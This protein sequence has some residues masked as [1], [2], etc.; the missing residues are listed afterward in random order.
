M[1]YRLLSLLT[2]V[3]LIL[4]SFTATIPV[5]RTVPI[6][7]EAEQVTSEGVLFRTTVTLRQPTE[8]ASLAKLGIVVLSETPDQAVVLVD[9]DQ[10]ETLARLRFEPA[11]SD[12]FGALVAAN[13]PQQPWLTESLQPLVEKAQQSAAQLAQSDQVAR[14]D[15]LVSLRAAIQTLSPEQMAGINALSS[16]DEDG[17]QLTNTQEAWWCTDTDNPD[18]DND[19]VSDF[20]EVKAAR[21]WLANRRSS[22]PAS[23]TPYR[24][25]PMVP[26][27]A[28]FDANCIDHDQDVVPD[29]AE[30]WELGLNP[31]RESTS[32]DKF[33]DGQKLF[34]ITKIN[35]GARPGLADNN[36]IGAE[37]P[38]WVKAPGNHPMV[39]AYPVPEVSVVPGTWHVNR[40]TTITTQQGTMMQS[41]KT[42]GSAVT[43][44]TSDSIANS[45]TWNNWEEVLQAVERPLAQAQKMPTTPACGPFCNVIFVE[46]QNV[47]PVIQ[48]QAPLWQ[49][50]IT[51]LGTMII[52]GIVG[53]AAWQWVQDRFRGDEKKVQQQKYEPEKLYCT[54]NP[55]INK[56]DA[57]NTC[58]SSSPNVQASANAVQPP[59]FQGNGGSL[60]GM[61]FA[62][63]QQGALITNGLHDVAYAISQPRLTETRTSG[64]SWGGA[65][66]TTHTEM[67]EHTLSESQAFTTG[68]N[69]S[70]AWAVDTSHAADLTFN[71]TVKN[72]G[73]EYAREILGLVFNVYLGNDTV[74]IVSYPAW[75]QFPAGK[76]QN[77]FPGDSFN[78]AST[79]IPLTLEQMKRIDLG[80]RLTVALENY[81][82]GVDQL[83]YQ[84]AVNGGVTIFTEGG[85]DDAGEQIDSYV[86][87]T[88]GAESVQ[89]VLTRYFPHQLDAEGLLN[90]L[91]TP[92]FVNNV[93]TWHEHYLSD[94]AWWNIYLSQSDAGNTELRDLPAQAGSA[95]FFRF[96]RDSDRD[97][98]P[99]RS[100]VQYGTDPHDPAS[101]PQ[102]ELLACY[103][104]TRV[105]N[106]VT[107]TLALDNAGTFDA[108]HI[109]AVM[110]SPDNTTTIGNNTVGG[111]GRVRPG[112]HVA[113]GSLIKQPG[114]GNWGANTARVYSTGDYGGSVDRTYTFT[115]N[116]PGV[117]GQGSA[118]MT[119]NDGA[120]VTGTLSLGASYHAPLPLDVSQ[121]LQV[122]FNTGTLNASTSFTVTAFS[123]RDT[124]TYTINS[125]PYTPPVIVVS[126]S[127]PQ[128]AHRFVT[129]VQLPDLQ[130]SLVPTYTGQMLTE[131][132]L[133]IATT[134][135]VSTTG[136]NT[137]NFIL[138]SPAASA[139]ADAHLY[140][141]FV[142]NG[143]LVLHQP[144]T[145][146]L[147]A[148]PMVYSAVWS[149]AQF[150]Q[151][152][153][154]A[155]DNILIAHWTDSEGNI[156][157][158]AARPLNTFASDPVPA[159]AMNAADQTWNF[160]TVTQG[161]VLQHSFTIASTGFINLAAYLGNT[162][163]LTVT[164]A[165]SRNLAPGDTATYT[166][167][168]NTLTQATSAFS[169]TLKLRTSDPANPTLTFTVLGNIIAPTGAANA[170]DL[171][172]RPWDK[173]VMVY[174]NV[175]QYTP[176]DFAENIQPDTASI[177]PCMVYAADGT[178]LK[179]IGKACADFGGGVS[180]GQMFGDGSDG[181]IAINSITAF[182]TPMSAL[183]NTASAGQAII[184]TV[185]A[186]PFEPGWEILLIQMQGIGTG[187]YEFAQVASQN[188][189]QTT[190][191]KPLMHTYIQSG[192]SKVFALKVPHFNNVTITSNGEWSAP[193]WDGSVGGILIFR[194][195]GRVDIQAGG[196]ITVKGRGYRS[197]DYTYG[198]ASTQQSQGEGYLGVGG[199]SSSS[200]SGGGGGGR[201][202]SGDNAYNSKGAG[203]GG[204][205]TAGGT[206]ATGYGQGGGTFGLP[207]LS[208]SLTAGGAG[209]ISG[210]D[211]RHTPGYRTYAFARN[212][213]GILV[214]YASK[215]QSLGSVTADG[216]SG[217]SGSCSNCEGAGGAGGSLYLVVGD[218][219]ASTVTAVG[220]VHYG[221]RDDPSGDG[222]LGRIR[223]EYCNSL[224]GTTNPP[225]STQ[226]LTCY[227]AE[228]T[229]NTNVHFTVPDA[230]T[231]SQ[232]YV[233]Q[234]GRYFAFGASGGTIMTPT[235]LLA[236]NYTNATMDALITNVGA[237]GSTNLQVM[238]GNQTVYSASQTITQPTS[239]S[240]GNFASALNAYL[241]A[242]PANTLIDVPM[243]VTLNR[244]ADV[245]LTNLALTP[246]ANVDASIAPDDI[247]FGAVTPTE[248]TTVPIT[249]TLHNT[250]NADS[251]G[252]TA[253]V[254]AT[255]T[256][257]STWYIGSAYVP[258]IPANGTM[259]AAIQ[260][261]TLGFTGTTPV[262]V[263]I[264][265]YNR[266]A[267]T[268]ENNNTV[269]T[270]LTIRT[271]PDLNFAALTLFNDEP[272]TNE[273]VTVT[274]PLHNLGQTAAGAY[275]VALYQGN[276]DAD[277]V[278]IGAVDQSGLAGNAT[279]PITF[280][281]T[282][283]AT[284]SYRLFARADRSAQIDEADEGNNDLWMDV[285]V[286][287]R[288]PIVIDSGAASDEPYTSTLGHGYVDLGQ[289]DVLV[290][291]GSQPHETLRMDP[292]GQIGYRFDHL[293][294]G[295]FYHLDVTLYECD[296]AGR[297]E[298]I[299][300]DGNRIAGPEDLLDGRVHRLS[301]R[302]DPALYADRTISVT[303][304][305]PSIDGAVVS[306]I[307][308]YDIDY[309]YADAGGPS[310]PAY[311]GGRWT[312]FG[313]A[314][315]YT[316]G[317]TNT[318]WGT[319]PYSNVH[320]NQISNTV[321]YRFDGLLPAKQY[322]VNLTFW[323]PSGASRAQKI[324]IDNVDTGPTINT[325]DYQ[326]HQLTVDVPNSAYAD[327]RI[328]VGIVRTNAAT[329]AFVNEIALE[330]LTAVLPPVTNFT[331][332]PT[333]G[334]APLTVQ[335]TDQ[336]SGVITSRSWNFGDG[337]TA[338]IANPLHA[339]QLSGT[340]TVSLMTTGPGGTDIL[341]RTNFITATPITTQTVMRIN[342]PVSSASVGLPITVAVMISNVTN[343][344]S[345]QFTLGFDPAR[346]QV[347]ALTLGEFP[348]S[349][350]RTFTPIGPT[351]DNGNGTA[352]FGAFSL[353]GTPPG[354][355]GSGNLAYIRLQPISGGVTALTLSN[356]QASTVSGG[357]FEVI[358]QTGTLS[359][360]ACLGDFDGDG[361]VDILD[362]Q[363]VA[364]RWGS[365][366][367]QA[368]YD[369]LYDVEPL[370][371]P[372]GDIG[373]LD[374]QVVA[375]RWGTQCSAGQLARPSA[376]T[377]PATL[378]IQPYS[379]TVSVNQIF[380]IS[381]WI[382]DV[383]DLGAFE[384][385]LAY[386]PTLIEVMSATIAPF[387]SSTGRAFTLA[388]FII[389]PTASTATYGA[390]SLGATPAGVNGNGA[391][392]ILTLKAL[393]AGQSGVNFTAAQISDRSG[394][395]QVI[396]S[397]LNGVVEVVMP[398]EWKVY[399]PAVLK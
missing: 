195:S 122:G 232:N 217:Y 312:T 12:E 113:V 30:T 184:N 9:A 138:N 145:L 19:G 23:G 290:P 162:S 236:Q 321:Y 253:A 29:A 381:V 367:G 191:T 15:A 325:G 93:P 374:V 193:A 336:S 280:T 257:G 348:G 216:E 391:L 295:H 227:I 74:P 298:N 372:D 247:T 396:G 147:N 394:A 204:H 386:S 55:Q 340:Y 261:N 43:R 332:A 186:Q 142:S 369:P 245:M 387:P 146:T 221:A 35:W 199:Q 116:I 196:Q 309:R 194:A 73:M 202:E 90:S 152:Y 181:D 318:L 254:F 358:T 240:L 205:A 255:P 174:G 190:L 100:E 335:F 220:G 44:G 242:Q 106:I 283:T 285:Y 297:Q 319:L 39:A 62:L 121:G 228:K 351:I 185:V 354:P 98:Y 111:N 380:T 144:Y 288:G 320:V 352:T 308:L 356:V 70:T 339:Y 57:N 67:E 231:N 259:Q 225:A 187:T 1:L 393:S 127:D 327:G 260:W 252:L 109:S 139:I 326:L 315:G 64:R 333:F 82:Y 154:A 94:I 17:D 7:K 264:D 140:V 203:G 272:V 246:G 229:S 156:I 119:W 306:A 314:Y 357:S 158:S 330:E 345:F 59:E 167:T 133:S 304:E 301:L 338:T 281:W 160:G 179:G 75:Q 324:Q 88:W 279:T 355:S 159:L 256:L 275:S 293:L 129:P 305:A 294:P 97:G 49:R 115:V 331:A 45:V 316:N 395:A 311:P 172:N 375:Y 277:G 157:D 148:G 173:R 56:I 207:D 99:D 61:Q 32:G 42:Y 150:T 378:S 248:G 13:A 50:A 360:A 177:E 71:Y 397:M 176:V 110:V 376:L 286:G 124:F 34:G 278:L 299:L 222:G 91:S 85:A 385:T 83:F 114:L 392:A 182:A 300:V 233:M 65:Q 180:S 153:D 52:G 136:A 307:N 377:A 347:Q 80:D 46:V 51:G 72:T 33:D 53:G 130:T 235:R 384:F 239:I 366:T 224:S 273:T 134:G 226:K 212:G 163:G 21:D 241:A 265:P 276:P 112:R 76:L 317:V 155:A 322:Q 131:V 296:G 31:N 128:G 343:L 388:G 48:Q 22:Y 24:S 238:V 213:G 390:F 11:A 4:T 192:N 223:I 120:G 20:D 170:F 334:Y 270:T 201:N 118:A 92:T 243:T 292:G 101:H 373:I 274:L 310:D 58:L 105:G 166:V 323:Q 96:N 282:P 237:G 287:L 250:G 143:E 126:Y 81:S 251:G 14:A 219:I 209:G 169:R 302:L 303:I 2:I 36:Q 382:S 341:T 108:Y 363:R 3:S 249:L 214:I 398:T 5:E 210:Y 164:G 8:R 25:W 18:S 350:G 102:P 149:T 151:T 284:G 78:F 40:V 168:L 263:V 368:L 27:D 63:N 349:T 344:G 77:V 26:G 371:A 125:E 60:E 337:G 178:T 87:P 38:T 161:E 183:A 329:G 175:A 197:P 266:V 16:I 383:A 346:V 215:L 54:Q 211:W 370:G 79:A 379:R 47:V 361:D 364:Y 117:V 6:P 37:M 104:T 188:G 41:S 342:P 218:V 234:F 10:L 135:P 353:G 28:N 84:N 313:R 362:V 95:L 208:Q 137:T 132:G 271:R 230:I 198:G 244:Q 267:E 291:C 86:I 399:L 89:A 268:D 103:A 389:S 69:W 200:N 171:V 107:A 66:T 365:H 141:D 206:S 289:P 258:S 359:I 123:P 262:H 68:E 189:N 269:T 165:T 328:E